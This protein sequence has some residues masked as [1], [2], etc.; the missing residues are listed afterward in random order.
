MHKDKPPRMLV[1]SQVSMFSESSMSQLLPLLLTVS[2]DNN[3]K[4]EI[5]SSSISVVVLSM[6][7]SLPLKK[8]SSRSKPLM[9]I[10]I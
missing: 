7:P 3:N 10:L 4:R 8:V 6:S 1:P 9:D 5:S 2:I